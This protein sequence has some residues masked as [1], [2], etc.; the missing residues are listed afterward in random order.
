MLNKRIVRV[1]L[2]VSFYILNNLL[3]ALLDIHNKLLLVLF[4]IL[5]GI[6]VTV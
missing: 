1:L 4:G 6:A 3:L 5:K 2:L